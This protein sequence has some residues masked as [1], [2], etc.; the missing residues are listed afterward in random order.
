MRTIKFRGLA[1]NKQW[2]VGSYIKTD[3]DAPC[4][5]YGDGEQE[6]IKSETIGQYT[7][8]LDKNLKE[9]YEGDIVKQPNTINKENFGEYSLKEIKFNNGAFLL[10]YLTSEKGQIIPRDYTAG[11][12]TDYGDNKLM[13]WGINPYV[14]DDLEVVGNIH[15]NPELL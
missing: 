15:Q 2:V 7:G 11:F 6:E 1:K 3:I 4:I 13:L 8:L 9:I 12:I 5:V 14:I 10:S